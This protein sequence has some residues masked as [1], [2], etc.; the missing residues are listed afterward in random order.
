VASSLAISVNV[1][2]LSWALRRRV[3]LEAPPKSPGM[4]DALLRLAPAVAL[5]VGLASVVASYLPPGMPA[6][7]RGGLLGGLSTLTCLGC[8][9]LLGVGEVSEVAR[10]LRTRLRRRR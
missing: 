9:A 3:G 6:L 4:V 8:A 7:V 1:L 10:G 5:G 2:A